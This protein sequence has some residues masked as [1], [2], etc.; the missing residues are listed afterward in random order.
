MARDTRNFLYQWEWYSQL[1]FLPIQYHMRIILLSNAHLARLE[2]WVCRMCCTHISSFTPHL[3]ALLWGR[4]YHKPPFSRSGCGDTGGRIPRSRLCT[5][6]VT[7]R[8]RPSFQHRLSGSPPCPSALC[9]IFRDSCE[10]IFY[11][12]RG[13]FLPL[14]KYKN[15]VLP[16][17]LQDG[18]CWEAKWIHYH[19]WQ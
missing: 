2:W 10:L 19:R 16:Q 7:G 13:K 17:F 1:V 9:S 5:Y 4:S 11:E 15:V 14:R 18:L 3:P 12:Q 8:A 6:L